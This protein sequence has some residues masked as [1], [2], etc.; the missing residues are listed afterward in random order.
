MGV[1]ASY[2]LHVL[3][4]VIQMLNVHNVYT[5][6]RSWAVLVNHMKVCG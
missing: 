4:G 6:G 3:K 2:T 5:I 1:S